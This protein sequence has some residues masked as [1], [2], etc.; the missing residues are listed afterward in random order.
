MMEVLEL[1]YIRTARAKG[2]KEGKVVFRHALRNA[3][4]PIIT[5][6][7][8]DLPILVGGAALAESV[9]NWPGTDYS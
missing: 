2:V 8:L 7:G 9:F 3:L 4:I 5:L 6:L 1:D